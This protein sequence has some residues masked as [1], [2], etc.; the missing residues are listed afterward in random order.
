M[1][2]QCECTIIGAVAQPPKV[3]D[4]NGKPVCSVQVAV[5]K[6]FNNQEFTSK[7]TVEGWNDKAQIMSKAVVNQQ[8]VAVG[9]LRNEKYT[10]SQGQ[11]KWTT[12][13]NAHS[14]ALGGFA[15]QQQTQQQ[16]YQGQ[17]QSYGQQQPQNQGYGQQQAPQNQQA[18][19]GQQP[20][21]QSFGGDQQYN[22]DNI[23]F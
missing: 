12:K 10:D 9:D 8:V 14:F 16:N 13:I 21:Q 2:Q 4:A 5:T 22:S 6:K 7:F 11:E 3:R 20:A 19:Y 23:P 18:Y 1:R 15:P 17:G